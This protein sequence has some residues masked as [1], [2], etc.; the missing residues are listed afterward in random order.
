MNWSEKMKKVCVV[1]GGSS[2]IGEATIEKFQSEGYKVY[3]L[4]IKPSLNS[5][6]YLKCDVTSP[7]AV[8]S[9]FDFI[10]YHDRYINNLVI[11]SGIHLSG[12]V[13]NTSL[14]AFQEIVDINVKGTYLILHYA[15][16]LIKSHGGSIVLVSSEQAFVG[17][18]NSFAY[19]LTKSAIA[20]MARTIA[21]DYAPFNIRCT[22][23]CPG[24][25]DTP[26]Y[27]KAIS[28]AAQFNNLQLEKI[29]KEEC[30]M[31]LLKRLGTPMEVA[32]L[33]NFLCS[34]K[35]GYIT[36]SLHVVDGGYTTI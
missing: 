6:Y 15:I 22:A 36:G 12:N 28:N 20:S 13:E 4:D 34:D 19:N 18:K 26:L 29:H 35:C 9:A 23:V 7:D 31:Q 17:K 27:R 14:D 21:I 30:E 2:G 3:N 10:R 32:E 16:G 5:S 25:I 1:V 8:K 11:S 24:T 33:I